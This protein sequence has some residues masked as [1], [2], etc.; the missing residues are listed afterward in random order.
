MSRLKRRALAFAL[1]LLVAFT[2]MPVSVMAADNPAEPP[3]ESAETQQ[4]APEVTDQG[5]S[6][7]PENSDVQEE[8]SEP[9]A[10]GS[11][12]SEPTDGGQEPQNGEGTE[13]PGQQAQDEADVL[14]EGGMTEQTPENTENGSDQDDM[15]TEG[16]NG[17]E[18]GT[19]ENTD[20]P[21]APDG[22]E[23]NPAPPEADETSDSDSQGQDGSDDVTYVIS[24]DISPEDSA[25]IE[26]LPEFVKEG[27]GFSFTV[28]AKDGYTLAEVTA[29]GAELE[30]VEEGYAVADVRNDVTIHVVTEK[31]AEEEEEEKKDEPQEEAEYVLLVSHELETDI[32]LFADYDKEVIL[33]AE[34]FANGSVDVLA[35]AYEREGMEVVTSELKVEK[36]D[37]ENGASVSRT[38]EYKVAE[39]YKAVRKSAFMLMA[40]YVGKLDDVEFEKVGQK[41]VTINFVSTNGTLM[42]EAETVVV[43]EENGIYSFDY[44]LSEFTGYDLD[45]VDNEIFKLD[46]EQHKITA[47]L[48]GEESVYEVLIIYKPQTKEYTVRHLYQNE[49]GR[50]PNET[51]KTE[52]NYVEKHMSGEFDSQTEA[53]PI[54]KEGFVSFP[55]EQQV[56]NGD[57]VVVTIQ[58][59]RIVYTLQYDSQGGSYIPPK[60]GMYGATVDV[61]KLSDS[62]EPKCGKEEHRWHTNACCIY[63]GTN[64]DHKYHSDDCCKYGGTHIHSNSCYKQVDPSPTRQ[65]Y[66]F[67]GWYTDSECKTKADETMLLDGNKTVYAKW[68][69]AEVN[70]TVVYWLEQVEEDKYD[71]KES[72]TE[73]AEVGEQVSGS[74]NKSIEYYHFDHADENVT[75][76]ADGS[77]VVN[78]YYKRNSYILKF[79][80]N[81][82]YASMTM[83]NEKY[84]N[85]DYTITARL[86]E[87][88]SS[89]WPM[90]TNVHVPSWNSRPFYGWAFQKSLWE[91]TTY[92]SKR[93]ELTEDML[94]STK[95]MST[96]K[97]TASYKDG[98]TV[99][100]HYMLQ[101]ADDN[102]YTDD[103][104]YSQ[105]AI[106]AYGSRD[107]SAKDI[108]GYIKNGS[109]TVTEGGIKNYYFYYDRKTY[110]IEYY[111]A[112]ENLKT[113]KSI[114]FGADI[115]NKNY[116]DLRPETVD[117][118][119][120][121]DGWYLN[122]E[123]TGE[124][125]VFGV[126]PAAN[127]KLYGKWILPSTS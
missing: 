111:Y 11:E 9:A 124:K 82:P 61:Y 66:T 119:A 41:Q 60:S 84:T 102:E 123:C 35:Y 101:N 109:R 30:T 112:G 114:R 15:T 83:G 97:Y 126:M 17:S 127:L 113:E 86:G 98:A 39:G 79:D 24:F 31:A 25:S 125:Y 28:S 121:F 63:S 42:R 94:S 104:R 81:D 8:Q 67:D 6:T 16:S 95:N 72:V 58:Y 26:G 12:V 27:E 108:L 19:T 14:P 118:D 1:T 106:E 37:F 44:S 2:N 117:S 5:D 52:D 65:G 7:A 89:K 93:F 53:V 69:P 78:V 56:I 34:D 92:V 23:E 85:D 10:D 36:G 70:Y 48:E 122:P 46:E 54:D 68:I 32:G 87:D 43:E 88:I 120:K 96:T 110:Q 47:E 91:E 59:E 4:D 90:S 3:V 20:T 18:D 100:L 80:L 71:Y 55:Y 107:Y 49:D 40:V 64:R 116:T 33:H 21:A 73:K 115:G 29:E 38:I 45:S 99:K 51:N 13:D 76:K 57:D 22:T 77:T 74:G 50:Y 105:D 62:R 103:E 75:V